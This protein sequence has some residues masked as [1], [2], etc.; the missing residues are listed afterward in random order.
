MAMRKKFYLVWEVVQQS[1]AMA[2]ARQK[3]NLV[4]AN[5][6]CEVKV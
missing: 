2:S 3:M 1:L 4:L 5:P 6:Q